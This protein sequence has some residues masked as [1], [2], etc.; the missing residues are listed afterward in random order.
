MK[1]RIEGSH[2]SAFIPVDRFKFP[3]GQPHVVVDVKGAK[4]AEI[5]ARIGNSDDL[6]S[7]LLVN[8]VLDRQGC[9]QVDL[10]ITYLMGAR[11]DRPID[12]TQPFTLRVVSLMLQDARFNRIRVLDPHSDV[13]TNQKYAVID[14]ILP[15]EY[16]HSAIEHVPSSFNDFALCAPDAGAA[17]RVDHFASKLARDAAEL[18]TGAGSDEPY[19]VVHCTKH[20]DSQT[21]KLSGFALTEG[22]KL[23]ENILIVDDICDGGRTFSSVAD[24]L[25]RQHG[26][27]WVGLYVTHG[28]FSNGFSIPGID[29]IFT[30][31]SYRRR[32]EYPESVTVLGPDLF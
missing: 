11:M 19:H 24:L 6:M 32:E 2:R 21:G 22:E 25:K 31:T 1:I 3:D 15:Y 30:T 23:F 8:D 12:A 16:V 9:A 18:A 27:K 4:K 7:L 17:K 20:R 10:F 26:V 14:A 28:I 5:F 13:T 29:Q